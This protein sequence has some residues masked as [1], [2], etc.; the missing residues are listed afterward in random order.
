MLEGFMFNVFMSIIHQIHIKH[1]G[2]TI[3]AIAQ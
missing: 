3:W 2:G 1:N